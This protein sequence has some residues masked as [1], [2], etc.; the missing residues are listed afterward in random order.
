MKMSQ[1]KIY[2]LSSSISGKKHYHIVAGFLSVSASP[3]QLRKPRGTGLVERAAACHPVAWL[4]VPTVT[5]WRLAPLSQPL[6]QH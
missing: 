2:L 6:K 3:E 4:A 5:F 1:K